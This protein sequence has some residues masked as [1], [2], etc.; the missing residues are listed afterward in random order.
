[1]VSNPFQGSL[2][3]L[4]AH[5]LPRRDGLFS[6]LAANGHLSR[7][8]ML[9]DSEIFTI[10]FRRLLIVLPFLA[11]RCSEL[12]ASLPSFTSEAMLQCGAL[13][14]ACRRRACGGGK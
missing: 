7:W 5:C 11:P 8:W 9:H 14:A 12:V 2:L 13:N 4:A 1:M 3:A 10:H 6:S